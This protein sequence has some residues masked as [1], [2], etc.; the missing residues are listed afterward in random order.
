MGDRR[1]CDKVRYSGHK[2]GAH[3]GTALEQMKESKKKGD[4]EAPALLTKIWPQRGERDERGH[5]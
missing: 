3:Q 1:A 4:H 5:E 2:R